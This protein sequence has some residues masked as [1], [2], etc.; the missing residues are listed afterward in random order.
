MGIP[1]ALTLQLYSLW[2]WHRS[3]VGNFW[4]PHY[5]R[6]KLPFQGEIPWYSQEP[7]W[8]SDYSVVTWPSPWRQGF[9]PRVMSGQQGPTTLPS[10]WRQGLFFPRP[11]QATG[12]CSLRT[13]STFWS[14]PCFYRSGA[15][16]YYQSV[17]L[18]SV[19][20][21]HSICLIKTSWLH[22]FTFWR[23]NQTLRS[24]SASYFCSV[25]RKMVDAECPVSAL[26][27]LFKRQADCVFFFTF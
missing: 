17:P 22:L 20:C 2:L 25:C 15:I 14:A 16:N 6:N 23:V 21:Q 26:D 19:L 3:W 5:K 18:L 4:V 11:C 13:A 12:A 1:L 9:F 24:L 27:Y 10:P 7:Y 8:C